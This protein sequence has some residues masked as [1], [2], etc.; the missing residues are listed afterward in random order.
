LALIIY[1]TCNMYGLPEV[2]VLRLIG[3]DY[4]V[5]VIRGAS[6]KGSKNENYSE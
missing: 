5:R 3:I 4:D 1:L 6:W 2:G